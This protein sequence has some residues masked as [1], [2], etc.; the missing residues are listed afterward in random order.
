MEKYHGTA[1]SIAGPAIPEATVSVYVLG[2]GAA[3][4]YEDNGVTPK[5]NPITSGIDGEY[6]F[7]AANGRYTIVTAKAGFA[8]DTRTDVML[9][10][11]ADTHAISIV[12]GSML[13]SA[14]GGCAT[15][16]RVASAANQPDITTLDFDAATEE[17]AQF[18]FPMPR[19]WDEGPVRFKIYWSHAATTTNFGVAWGLQAV[20]VSNDD[21]IAVAFGTAVV[22]TDTGGTTNDLYVTV[23]SAEMTVGGTPQPEDMVFFRVFRKVSDAADTMA[24][25]ARLHT[26]VLF[27]ETSGESDA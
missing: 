18:F 6:N 20:A 4:I 16:A 27:I 17:Y 25:D 10:D 22:V 13:P 14:A 11:P 15:L 8:T 19:S 3:T 5:A 9:Y 12:S 23:I 21:G 24:I 26:L 7:Y 2:G 1:L